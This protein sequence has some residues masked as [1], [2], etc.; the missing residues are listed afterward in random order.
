MLWLA[1]AFP[2]LPIEVFAEQ[3]PAFRNLDASM[4][5]PVVVLEDNRVSFCNAAADA[6]GIVPGASLA[7]AHT[8]NSNEESFFVGTDPDGGD[9]VLLA[10][11][12][13]DRANS[14]T[15][16]RVEITIPAYSAI[17]E[18]VAQPAHGRDIPASVDPP[19][20]G[21]FACFFGDDDAP[22]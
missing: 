22:T 15:L 9:K 17:G 8:I 16:T 14:P 6:A 13:G 7:T 20:N 3:I 12:T 19:R 11:L 21:W 2:R 18:N 5:Q 10:R 1:I 4:T